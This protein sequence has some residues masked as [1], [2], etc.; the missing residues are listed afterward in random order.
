MKGMKE[1]RRWLTLAYVIWTEEELARVESCA[2]GPREGSSRAVSKLTRAAS[3]GIPIGDKLVFL[4]A[5][6]PDLN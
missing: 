2:E 6:D 1:W 3:V 5:S 4:V